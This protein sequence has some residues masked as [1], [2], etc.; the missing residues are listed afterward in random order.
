MI[1]LSSLGF[2]G[3]GSRET[4]DSE[5][6]RTNLRLVPRLRTFLTGR[7]ISLSWL[8]ALLLHAASVS[9]AT[10]IAS[11]SYAEVINDVQPR[12]VKIF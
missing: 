2:S 3:S 7:G 1:S 4:S 5:L 11:P 12:M 6:A 9:A 8:A 10:G